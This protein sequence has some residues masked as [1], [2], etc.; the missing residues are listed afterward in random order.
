M[1]VVATVYAVPS[2]SYPWATPSSTN[3]V[4]PP[5]SHTPMNCQVS[6]PARD[7][8]GSRQRELSGRGG[9][10]GSTVTRVSAL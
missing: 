2:S 3:G 4:L 10:A 1:P 9:S 8:A 6:W 7:A 5:S